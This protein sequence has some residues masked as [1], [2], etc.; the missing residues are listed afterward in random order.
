M[1]TTNS[2]LES[3]KNFLGINCQETSFDNELIQDINLV[4]FELYQL[5]VNDDNLIQISGNSET[6]DLFDDQNLVGVVS[7]YLQLKVKKIFDPPTSSIV[8][9]SYDSLLNEY[10]WRITAELNPKYLGEVCSCTGS[11]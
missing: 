3:V 2:I 5:G 8:A 11:N 10:Q 1:V 6:W 7:T 4:L 9:N